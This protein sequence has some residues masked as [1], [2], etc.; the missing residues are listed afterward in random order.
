MGA[1]AHDA[2]LGEDH[3]LVRVADG[4]HA[5][6]D[7]ERG[8]VGELGRQ[9]AAQGRVG[10]EVQRREGVVEDVEANVTHEG[11]GDGQ[12]LALAAAEV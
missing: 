2:A 10:A 5:L 11:A 1:Q 4:A 7:D 3:D 8:R 9:R 12:A 6:R